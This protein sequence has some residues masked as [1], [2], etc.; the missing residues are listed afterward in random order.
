MKIIRHTLPIPE[1]GQIE[2]IG[3]AD[4]HLGDPLSDWN[5]IKRRVDYIAGTPGAYCLLDGDLLDNATRTSIGDTYRAT[6]TPMQGVE[7][8]VKLLAPIKGKI[9]AAD[10][11]NHEARSYRTDGLDI[12]ALVCQQ[13]GIPHLYSETT[14]LIELTVGAQKYRL[15]MTH[16]SGGGRKAGGKINRLLDLAVITDAD[17]YIMAHTH[18]PMA[19]R[20]AVMVPTRGDKPQQIE[21]LFVMLAA[22]LTYGGYADVQGYAPAATT[23]PTIYLATA[24]KFAWATV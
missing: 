9:L 16:G 10:G 2:I 6:L 3:M 21:K 22:S 12:T 15:Y 20:Q 4:L 24:K 13:L 14:C 11:G 17:V 19:T 18:Q 8:L 5:S 1:N 23:N 7:L